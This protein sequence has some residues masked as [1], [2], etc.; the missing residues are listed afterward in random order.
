MRQQ[1]DDRHLQG[2]GAEGDAEG[3]AGAEDLLRFALA[4]QVEMGQAADQPLD[5][6]GN[7]AGKGGEPAQGEAV[8]AAGKTDRGAEQRDRR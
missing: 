7:A 5:G 1:Q 4:D 8:Q 6:G 3:D 2:F